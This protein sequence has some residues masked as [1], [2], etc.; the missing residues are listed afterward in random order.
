MQERNSFDPLLVEK[1]VIESLEPNVTL[2]SLEEKHGIP[3]AY[4][5]KYRLDYFRKLLKTYEELRE[6]ISTKDNE[7]N[8]KLKE[9]NEEVERLKNLLQQ[10]DEIIASHDVNRNNWKYVMPTAVIAL[11]S[12]SVLNSGM[13]ISELFHHEFIGY[14]VSFVFCNTPLVLFFLRKT[15][16]RISLVVI[17]MTLFF[18]IICN[19]YNIQLKMGGNIY[20]GVKHRLG[21]DPFYLS[22]S[23]SILLPTVACFLEY[24]WLKNRD[25]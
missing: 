19:L 20:D 24:L 3:K 18:E 4:I 15:N 21:I 16:M 6:T 12:S 11:T 10:Q 17:L 23:I 7:Y 22:L 1:A 25:E 8:K 2:D 5:G 14:I 9:V 13:V